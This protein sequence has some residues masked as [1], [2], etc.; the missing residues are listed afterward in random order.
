MTSR[1]RAR[2]RSGPAT[3]TFILPLFGVLVAIVLVRA[4]RQAGENTDDQGAEPGF[5]GQTSA[6]VVRV[7]PDLPPL[8]LPRGSLPRQP[9]AVQAAYEFAARHPEVLERLPC[10]CGC[11]R[12]G[13]S[14][15]RQ[16]FVSGRRADG[17][18]TWDAH[19]M[20]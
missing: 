9:P 17:R 18:V 16:C 1:R 3:V 6:Q 10:F 8:P 13:H 5:V 19:G 14:S 15:N 7:A 12:L 20:G 4:A 2:A 11:E